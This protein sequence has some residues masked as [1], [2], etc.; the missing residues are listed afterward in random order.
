MARSVSM[1]GVQARHHADRQSGPGRDATRFVL[2]GAPEVVVIQ[3]RGPQVG[4]NPAHHGNPDVDLADGRLDAV[5]DVARRFQ[6]TQASPGRGKV[7][8]DPGQQ[9]SELVVELAGDAR[10]LLLAHLFQTFGQRPER[11]GVRERYL[12]CHLKTCNTDRRCRAV[13]SVKVPWAPGLGL[14][15]GKSRD[16]ERR[17]SFDLNGAALMR[18]PSTP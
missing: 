5:D 16:N 3:L 2:D 6:L 17:W 11:V 13:V 4:G 14:R 9:L 7:E 18:P 15:C 10:S 8:L 1:A 12:V